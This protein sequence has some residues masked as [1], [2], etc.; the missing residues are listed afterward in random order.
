MRALGVFDESTAELEKSLTA[1]S[2]SLQPV[3]QPIP[4]ATRGI[5]FAVAVEYSRFCTTWDVVQISRICTIYQYYRVS[6]YL[7]MFKLHLATLH[8]RETQSFPVITSF[9]LSEETRVALSVV[10]EI[11]LP[12]FNV[13]S[14]VGRIEAS[15]SMIFHSVICTENADGE[16][17][18]LYLY[19]MNIRQVIESLTLGGTASVANRELFHSLNPLPGASWRSSPDEGWILENPDDIWPAV[20]S[21]ED[22]ARDILAYKNLLNRAG[23]RVPKNFIR[24]I[25]WNGEAMKG[26]FVSMDPTP[27]R[28]EATFNVPP[29]R[30]RASRVRDACGNAVTNLMTTPGVATYLGDAID[31]QG[32]VTK[33]WAHAPDIQHLEFSVGAASQVG[34]HS[35]QPTRLEISSWIRCMVSPSTVLARLLDVS[36]T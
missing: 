26:G 1:M 19:P 25:T 10:S 35:K 21:S 7:L 8:Q 33:A 16:Q 2:L 18:A 13:I 29:P 3:S 12:T 28:L 17:A 36:R 15:P 31:G 22:L 5:G 20:Y 30:T 34:E 23:H 14:C 6:M 11:P 24:N 4:V 9:A 27:M 32:C